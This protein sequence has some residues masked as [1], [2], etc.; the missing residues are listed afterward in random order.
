LTI[1]EAE[2]LLR[3]VLPGRRV[4]ACL[5]RTG[6]EL[7]QV[8]QAQFT[9]GADPVIIK[10]YA[11]AWRW[12]Q[13]KEANIYQLLHRHQVG[14]TP[15]V[16]HT[17]SGQAHPRGQAYTV[18]TLLPGQPLSAVSGQLTESELR[19][20]YRRM[21]SILAALHDIGQDAFGYLTTTIL[22]PKPTNTAYM[23]GQFG[24]K[25]R[26]FADLGGD[27]ALR[28][29]IERHVAERTELFAACEHA[30]LCHND[31]H[32]GNVLIARDQHGDWQVTGFVDVENAIAADPLIDLAK[33]DSYSIRGDHFAERHALYRLYHALELWDWFASIGQTGHL[34][35]LADDMRQL[36]TPQV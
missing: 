24:K 7:S 3:E 30:A 32:E 25:L 20:V 19:R 10:I 13:D 15:R 11:E 8:Y 2:L 6:G 21:G 35:D 4:A 31:F 23:T 26:E 16:L 9:D 28:S 29:A 1:D 18:M 22:D 27:D 12:K 34:P 14:P 17:D 5:P 33:T 36:T